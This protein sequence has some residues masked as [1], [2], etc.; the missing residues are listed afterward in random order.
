MWYWVCIW[1]AHIAV[2]ISVDNIDVLSKGIAA[3]I[4]VLLREKSA[5]GISDRLREKRNQFHSMHTVVGSFMS[6]VSIL[7]PG[8]TV[9]RSK[10]T[11]RLHRVVGI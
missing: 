8:G 9:N 6:S 10:S 2:E 11:S 3:N 7:R 5:I 1:H 4:R